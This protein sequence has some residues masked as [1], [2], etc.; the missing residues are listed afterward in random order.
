MIQFEDQTHIK[1]GEFIVP[2]GP[3]DFPMLAQNILNVL[4]NKSGRSP[5]SDLKDILGAWGEKIS[6]DHW[7]D[8]LVWLKRSIL[9]ESANITFRA[10]LGDPLISYPIKITINKTTRSFTRRTTTL[11]MIFSVINSNCTP[12]HS[13]TNTKC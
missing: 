13:V 4:N 7:G 5:S 6:C 10:T 12:R 2:C 1:C 9:E 11:N 8:L 3:R